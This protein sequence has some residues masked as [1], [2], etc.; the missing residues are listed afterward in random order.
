MAFSRARIAAIAM[1][2]TMAAEPAWAHHVMGGN[3]PETLMQ[4]LLSGLGHP[5]ASR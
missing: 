5:S 1:V 4:G 3:M 2:V